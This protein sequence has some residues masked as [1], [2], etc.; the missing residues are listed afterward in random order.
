MITEIVKAIICLM[1]KLLLII[2]IAFFWRVIKW[3]GSVHGA[4]IFPYSVL[5]ECLRNEYYKIIV[6][7]ED[8]VPVCYLGDSAYPSL[9]FLMKEFVNEGSNKKE[10]FLGIQIFTCTYGHWMRVWTTKRE[11]W[12]LTKGNGYKNRRFSIRHS[13]LFFAT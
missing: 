4:R 6:E 9:P 12:L 3:P 8:T 11:V 5:N 13:C 7:G 2:N 10:H 1:R